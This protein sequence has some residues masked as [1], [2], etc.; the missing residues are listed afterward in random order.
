MDKENNGQQIDQLLR[1]IYR[2]CVNRDNCEGCP[3]YITKCTFEEPKPSTWFDEE[4]IETV[5]APAEATKSVEPVAGFKSAEPAAVKS[6]EPVAVFKPAEPAAEAKSE[7]TVAGF[8]P[9]EP[10]EKVKSAE[11]SEGFKLLSEGFKSGSEHSEGLKFVSDGYK[12]GSEPADGLGLYSESEEASLNRSEEAFFFRRSDV[13]EAE[14][15]EETAEA[16]EAVAEET[17]EAPAEQPAEQPAVLETIEQQ[18]KEDDS[19]GTW[20]VST[21]MGSVFTKYVFICSKCGYRKESFFSIT[22]MT[23]CP[24]CANRKNNP[25]PTQ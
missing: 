17:A 14:E 9:A 24:E 11:P 22:P 5:S 25:V 20:L 15:P 10:A 1:G 21:T 2:M 12:L 19:E 4:T 13:E 7:E 3:F 18:T 6:V 23:Y 16:A 8:K